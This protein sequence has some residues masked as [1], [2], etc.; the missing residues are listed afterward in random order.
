MTTRAE[1][2][3]DQPFTLGLSAGFF[4]FY[5]HAGVLQALLD[6]GLVPT[7]VAGA[8]AGALVGGLWAA[9]TPVETLVERLLGLQRPEFWDPAPGAG[10]LRGQRFD[11][12]LDELMPAR[13]FADARV[14]VTV[15]AF[16]IRARRTVTLRR[17]DLAE[18]IRAS[19]SFPGLFHP[20]RIDGRWLSDGGILDR[21][22][23][24]GVP[25]GQRVLHHHLASR[26]PWR[27]RGSPALQAPERD[28]LT[29]LVVDGLPRVNPF[30]LERGRAAYDRAFAAAGAWLDEPV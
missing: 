1:A 25:R 18:A 10:L 4:G 26:S 17:G 24:Q 14:P 2:L 16:D 15:S 19:C 8:S 28:G 11:A 21:A 27:R 30:R 29:P 13:G 23:L 6:R 3:R 7:A 20:V 12:I 9:G 22:G 5:A